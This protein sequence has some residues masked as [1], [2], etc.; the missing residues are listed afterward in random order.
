M[1]TASIA[2]FWCA[3]TANISSQN[4]PVVSEIWMKFCLLRPSNSSHLC[5]EE[6]LEQAQCLFTSSPVGWSCCAS[7]NTVLVVPG[8]FTSRLLLLSW[9][10]LQKMNYI[11]T[12]ADGSIL[13]IW[14]VGFLNL[15]YAMRHSIFS[16]Q[17]VR[18]WNRLVNQAVFLPRSLGKRQK[19]FDGSYD[20]WLI[21]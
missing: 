4:V 2:Y 5:L 8:A 18:N 17:N 1:W 7:C 19:S 6:P 16:F 15:V 20:Y 21:V 9:M 14:G 13:C 11:P 3:Q 12:F 10:P